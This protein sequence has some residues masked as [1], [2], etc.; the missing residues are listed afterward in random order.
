VRRAL[1]LALSGLG[2]LAGACARPGSPPGGPEDRIPPFVVETVPDTFAVVEGFRGPVVLRFSERISERTTGGNWAD[3]ITLTPESG[4]LRVRVRRDA[5]EIRPEN[6]FVPGQVYRVTLA[7][8]VRDLFGNTIPDPFEF[9]F[10]TGG[11]F[12]PGVVGG[13]AWDRV[14]GA[15]L[16][17]LRV[18]MVGQDPDVTH[19]ARSDTAGI[20]LFRHLDGGAYTVTGYDDRNRSR[21][22]DA[23][24]PSG[25]RTLLLE[26]AD[27]LITFLAVLPADTTPAVLIGAELEDSVTVRL[28][29]D[30]PLDPQ[31]GGAELV[32]RLLL[33][34]DSSA[35]GITGERI[36]RAEWE[37]ERAEPVDAEEGAE[38]ESEEGDERD[39]A[40]TGP[41]GSP[42]PERELLVRLSAPPEFGVRYLI[43]VEGVVNLRR[44]PAGGGRR[45]LEREPPA[46]EPEPQ[47]EPGPDPEAPPEPPADSA[48]VPAPPPPAPDTLAGMAAFPPGGSRR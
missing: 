22:L 10:S 6:G 33:A 2:L 31:R 42:L 27:T 35:T 20:F 21:I 25:R 34:A 40:P 1:I 48:P 43:E 15:P 13:L 24:E 5:L 46:A 11:T 17:N 45:V 39:A 29:F 28:D 47:P 14:T 23:G 41:D 18:E 8:V 38:D 7:P 12:E 16:R 26:P 44:I 4:P 19:V 32:A 9:A 3:V 30:D 37:R 36:T